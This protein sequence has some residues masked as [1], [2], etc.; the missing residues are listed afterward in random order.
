VN[1]RATRSWSC[2]TYCIIRILRNI[3]LFG[4]GEGGEAVCDAVTDELQQI[5]PNVGGSVRMELGDAAARHVET[6]ISELGV[7]DVQSPASSCGPGQARPVWARPKSQPDNG[8][9][10]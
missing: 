7:S 4:I 6:W 8:F 2:I 5:L 1:Q 3:C 10:L 9:G